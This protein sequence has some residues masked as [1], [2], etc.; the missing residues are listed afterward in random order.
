MD[1]NPFE[2]ELSQ[3]IVAA[4]NASRHSGVDWDAFV[5]DYRTRPI[6]FFT[7]DLN[8]PVRYHEH[9]DCPTIGLEAGAV[10]I[11]IWEED[12]VWERNKIKKDSQALSTFDTLEEAIYDTFDV[13]ADLDP[14]YVL[15]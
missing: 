10:R 8:T 2:P 4:Q 12:G 15:S 7:S 14:E 6:T 1:I 3:A 9:V 13:A 5:S 11:E